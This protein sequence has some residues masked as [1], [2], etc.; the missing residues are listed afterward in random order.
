MQQP[1]TLPSVKVVIV[2]NLSLCQLI[3]QCKLSSLVRILLDCG[4][5]G[6]LRLQNWAYGL[7]ETRL[8]EWN[9]A[10]DLSCEL[11]HSFGLDFVI[12]SQTRKPSLR[13]TVTT[14]G[15]AEMA[16]L[17]HRFAHFTEIIRIISGYTNGK[18][19][20]MITKLHETA[21]MTN[22]LNPKLFGALCR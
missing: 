3:G 17:M 20:R 14:F 4:T 5:E 8:L 19:N 15:I 11:L 9:K 10:D 1:W 22:L 13:I 21:N 6:S 2:L 18:K 16:K 7:R 12:F